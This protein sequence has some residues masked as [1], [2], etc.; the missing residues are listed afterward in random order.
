MEALKVSAQGLEALGGQIESRAHCANAGWT[1]WT[2]DGLS[3]TQGRGWALQ[4]VELRLS[5]PAAAVYDVYY[6]VHAANYGWLSWAANGATAGTTGMNY[7][8]EA[9]EI[10]L[11]RKGA[12]APGDTARPAVTREYLQARAGL[13]YQAHVENVGWQNP[14]GAGAQA[15][16]TGRN[17]SVEAFN[18]RGEQ[19]NGGIRYQA[20]V[21][22]IGW[23]GWKRDGE[24]VGTTGRNLKMEAFQAELYGEAATSYD[25]YYQVHS[26]DYGWLGWAKNGQWA[27]TTGGDRKLQAVRIVLV[28]KGGPAPGSTQTPYVNAPP[29]PKPKPPAPAAPTGGDSVLIGINAQTLNFY[30]NG[31]LAMSTPVTTGL[32]GVYDTPTGNYYLRSKSRNVTLTGDGYASFVNYWM[33]FIGQSYGL[34]DADGWRSNYGGNVYIYDGSHGCVN[35]PYQAAATLYHN[36]SVGTPIVIRYN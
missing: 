12:G 17:L 28:V 26:E 9:V 24:T 32:R 19:L 20:H 34:H 8:A 35:M 3:G 13:V 23:Q 31:Q 27:G 36:I 7:P 30:R 25:V 15:G 22:N 11:V 10:R 5:G 33:P 21:S 4:A 16:T 14:V 2:A 29:K 18:L 6:R 1:D